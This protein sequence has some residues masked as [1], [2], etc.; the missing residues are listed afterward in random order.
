MKVLQTVVRIVIARALLLTAASGTYAAQYS[1]QAQLS[2]KLL[3]AARH[4]TSLSDKEKLTTHRCA[5][6]EK[7]YMIGSTRALDQAIKASCR[8][9]MIGVALYAGDDLGKHYPEKLANLSPRTI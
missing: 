1:F 7:Y 9:L 5:M 4:D 2:A 8:N 3:R 6:I